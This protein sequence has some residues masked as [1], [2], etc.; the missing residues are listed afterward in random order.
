MRC[1]TALRLASRA[2]DATASDADAASLAEHLAS[3]EACRLAAR[4]L[5]GAWDALAP[6]GRVPPAPDDWA[7][8]EARVESRR[9]RWVLPWEGWEVGWRPAAG[10]VLAGM[11]ALGA[12]GGALLGRAATRSARAGSFEATAFAETLGD[13]P[14]DSPAA[15]LARPLLAAPPSQGAR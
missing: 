3:C 9:R 8:I 2:I 4:A 10:L 12:T 6:L 1:K 5:T 15:G 13:L 14:W 7:R 11:V